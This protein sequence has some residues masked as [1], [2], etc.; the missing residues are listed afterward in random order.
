[1][2]PCYVELRGQLVRLGSPGMEL[3][4]SGS[5]AQ[6]FIHGLIFSVQL[7]ASPQ[8]VT[9]KGS[10]CLASA[11]PRAR[12]ESSLGLREVSLVF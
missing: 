11:P 5:V 3:G 4:F 6:A 8:S 2:T 10:G 12:A 1:V 9:N 7:L